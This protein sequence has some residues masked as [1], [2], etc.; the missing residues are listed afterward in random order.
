MMQEK[1]LI[2]KLIELREIKPDKDWVS[3]NKK[4]LFKGE[5]KGF[6]FFPGFKPAFAGFMVF[7]LMLGGVSYGL[8][9][10][11]MPGDFLYS[12]RKAI[13]SGEAIFVSKDD[14]S[15][16]QLKLANDRLEDLVNA[17]AKNLAPTMNEFEANISEAV[18]NLGIMQVSTSSPETIQKLVKETRKLEENKEKVEALG[19]VLS[20]KET[21]EL[22]EA[23]KKIVDNLITDLEE[24]ELDDQK[25]GILVKMK[26]LFD[27]E[28][29][30]EALELYLVNQ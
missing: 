6:A 17:S 26:E 8:V 25:F 9:K 15:A 12:V 11:A 20:D 5:D 2:G 13:H 1:E 19:V 23:F 22:N 21:S 30:S 7:F 27:E 16:F 24:R 29:Y 14:Q 3:F 28:Q 10:N 18:R 4:E